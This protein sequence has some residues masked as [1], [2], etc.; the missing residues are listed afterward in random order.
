MHSMHNKY[1]KIIN[2]SASGNIDNDIIEP[3]LLF[4]IV[5]AIFVSS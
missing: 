3:K 2:T 4:R 5:F 1:K